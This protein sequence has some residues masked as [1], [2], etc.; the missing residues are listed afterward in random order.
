MGETLQRLGV[1]EAIDLVVAGGSAALLG[2]LHQPGRITADCDVVWSGDDATWEQ[3]SRAA[4]EVGSG[5][6]LPPQWL[7][8]ECSIF[9]WCI[10]FGWYERTEPVGVFGPLRVRRLH[11]LDLMGMKIVSAPRRPQDY[12][13][14]EKMRPSSEDLNWIIQHLDRLASEHLGGEEFEQQRALV[15]SLRSKP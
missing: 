10:P 13:D 5:L 3:I 14:I 7:N 15:E 6:G 2:S 8:R 9:A 1:G 11:R 12:L 4:N